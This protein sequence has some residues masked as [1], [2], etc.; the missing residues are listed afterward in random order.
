[1]TVFEQ[2]YRAALALMPRGFRERH[3][4]DAL[5]MAVS[6]VRE[7]AGA[8]RVLRAAGELLDLLRHVPRIRR[9]AAT[10][11]VGRGER[12]GMRDGLASD[13]RAAAD[14][15]AIAV[16]SIAFAACGLLAVGWPARTAAS[17]DPAAA[18]RN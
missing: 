15:A 2:L 17:T 9:D 3:G 10:L 8:R 11:P 6:R 5:E 13:L 4:A 1:M 16:V 14:P 12:G 7:E 18:L